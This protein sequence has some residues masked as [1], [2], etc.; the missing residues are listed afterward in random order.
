M[1]TTPT[2]SFMLEPILAPNSDAGTSRD[3]VALAKALAKG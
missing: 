3:A 2:P 1:K